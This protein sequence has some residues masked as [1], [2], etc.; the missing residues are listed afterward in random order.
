MKPKQIGRARTLRKERT[1]SKSNVVTVSTAKTRNPMSSGDSNRSKL[2]VDDIQYSSISAGFCHTINRMPFAPIENQNCHQ[3]NFSSL[4]AFKLSNR[5]DDV[6]QKAFDLK[7]FSSHASLSL[8]ANVLAPPFD[9]G[10]RS[11]SCH[12]TPQSVHCSVLARVQWYS[13]LPCPSTSELTFPSSSLS[14]ERM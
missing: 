7:V 13:I 11:A 10:D 1:I 8:F 14:F 12:P 3:V 2:P 6:F 9:G 4:A 5:H